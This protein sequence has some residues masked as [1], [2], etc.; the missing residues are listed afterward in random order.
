MHTI[1]GF[2]LRKLGNEYILVGESMKLINFNKMITLNET[3]AFLWEQA[4]KG[5]FDE[6][7]LSKALC[8]EYDV[9]PEQALTDVTAT[10]KSWLEAGVIE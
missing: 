10:I 2:K 6:T 9:A 8:A 4:D 5:E 7:T 3:A 1:E